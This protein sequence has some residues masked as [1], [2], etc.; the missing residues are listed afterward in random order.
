[1][2]FYFVMLMQYQ[3]FYILAGKYPLN[4]NQQG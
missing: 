3:F 2:I 1:M 4:H